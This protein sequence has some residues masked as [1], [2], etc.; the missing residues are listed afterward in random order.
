VLYVR[1]HP[2]YTRRYRSVRT[3]CLTIGY[4]PPAV[5]LRLSIGKGA[6][7]PIFVPLAPHKDLEFLVQ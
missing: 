2:Y 6:A 7:L 3:V 4:N 5:P 1:P